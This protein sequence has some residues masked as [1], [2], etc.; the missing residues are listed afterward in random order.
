V[1]CDIIFTGLSIIS[2]LL[3]RLDNFMKSIHQ[4]YLQF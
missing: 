3:S 4:F 2:V 1:L